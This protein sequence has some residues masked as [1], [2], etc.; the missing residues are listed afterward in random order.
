MIQTADSLLTDNIPALPDAPTLSNIFVPIDKVVVT[1]NALGEPT[2]NSIGLGGV[3]P[4]GIVQTGLESI[5][6]LTGLP[7][8]G[9]I[10]VA[11][12]VIRIL[13]TPLVVSAQ[14]NSAIFSN[15]MGEIQAIQEKMNE[16]RQMKNSMAFA[17]HSQ[18]M[19][20]LMQEK[21]YNPI[22]NF[23]VP[24]AQMPIFLSFYF[25]LRGMVNAPVE[26][27]Q[28]GG[29]AWFTDLTMADPYYILPVIT[30]STLWLTL[31]YATAHTPASTD[32]SQNLTIKLM[33]IMP[34]VMFPIIFSFP[35]A[36]VMYWASSNICSLIQVRFEMENI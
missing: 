9:T 6:I 27:F 36:L 28:N 14:K 4:S 34:I 25:G 8:W 26:S 10:A 13:L 31:R 15:S 22:K 16:A 35:S 3:S 11:T 24:F 19:M 18:E 20:N 23:L 5:H 2:L 33:R 32:T 17:E 1:T 7:W 21:G 12:V 30:C 29:I